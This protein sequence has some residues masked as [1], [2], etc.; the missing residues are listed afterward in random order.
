MRYRLDL[1]LDAKGKR[2]QKQVSGFTSK[3]DAQAALNEA[4]T[5]V[6][7][8]TYIAPSRQTVARQLPS[9]QSLWSTTKAERP[10]TS[11]PA[12]VLFSLTPGECRAPWEKQRPGRTSLPLSPPALPTP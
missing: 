5:G 6:Q 12:A 3:K 1:G 2:A 9:Q 7:R 8:G 11:D 10:M 4:L